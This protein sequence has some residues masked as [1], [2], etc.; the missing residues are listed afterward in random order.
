M[1]V[2]MIQGYRPQNLRGETKQKQNSGSAYAKA[3]KIWNGTI[4]MNKGT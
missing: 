1:L 3:K 2:G 4:Q